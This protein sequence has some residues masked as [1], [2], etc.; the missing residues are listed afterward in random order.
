[1]VSAR[2]TEFE[3]SSPRL[4]VLGR[5][6]LLEPGVALVGTIRSD[7]T[8]RISPVEPMVWNGDLWLGMMWGSRKARDL[9]RDPRVLVHNV[10]SNRDGEEG[11]F[12]VRG[13]A[14]PEE[15]PSHRAGYIDAVE[16]A[17][18]WRPE[19]RYL[20]LFRIEVEDV[21]FIRYEDGDQ[22]VVRWPDGEHVIRRITSATSVG[23]PEDQGE[24]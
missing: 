7:G 24:F 1:V 3:A 19:D 6:R 9:L 21:T 4:A 23:E 10:I 11:E 20:H 16:A 13:L 5:E 22:R 8:A 18:D 2:W 14:E 15:D 17:L 12:K